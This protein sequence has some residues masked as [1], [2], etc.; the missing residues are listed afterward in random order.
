[1]G[2]LQLTAVF[3][4]KIKEVASN[5]LKQKR[6]TMW[7]WSFPQ[8]VR[9]SLEWCNSLLTWRIV[10]KPNITVL[11]PNTSDLYYETEC[12]YQVFR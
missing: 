9:G 5:M 3:I 12:G 4:R 6:R 2:N 7:C 8:A 1:M 11:A 10:M